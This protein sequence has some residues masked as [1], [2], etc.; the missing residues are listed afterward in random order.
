MQ[1]EVKNIVKTFGENIAVDNVSFSAKSGH[2]FGLL[3]RNGA[4]L[5][6][7]QCV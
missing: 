2:V 5:K 4:G 6:Q 3:G 1:I 7:Q